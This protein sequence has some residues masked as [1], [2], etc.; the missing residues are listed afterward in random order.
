MVHRRPQAGGKQAGGGSEEHLVPLLDGLFHH[1]KRIAVQG[2]AV[3]AGLYLPGKHC[4]QVPAAQLMSI[5]PSGGLRRLV[6]E[7][8]HL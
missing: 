8:G 5:G 3:G 1:H 7:K 2:V 6:V 4:L